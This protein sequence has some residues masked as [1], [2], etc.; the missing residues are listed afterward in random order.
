MADQLLSGSHPIRL[1]VKLE[2][3][4][5][6]YD[7]LKDAEASRRLAKHTIADV[8]NAQEAMNDDMFEDAAELVGILARMMKRGQHQ[9]SNVILGS[10]GGSS[11]GNGN[12]P[13]SRSGSRGK[14]S[15]MCGDGEDGGGGYSYTT[16]REIELPPSQGMENLI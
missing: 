11:S 5:F 9:G 3:A 6:M 1:S 7:C 2:W 15:K 10:T 8:Y 16:N 14:T 12:T 13:G 4:A